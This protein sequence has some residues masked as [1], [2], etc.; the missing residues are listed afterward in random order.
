M[1]DMAYMAEAELSATGSPGERAVE[2]LEAWQ[3]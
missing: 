2:L 1:N 3:E